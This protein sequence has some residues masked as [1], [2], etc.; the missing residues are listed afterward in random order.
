MSLY[1]I[2]LYNGEKNHLLKS[3]QYTKKVSDKIYVFCS[4]DDS[5]S[6]RD[7]EN[8]NIFISEVEWEQDFSKLRNHAIQVVCNDGATVRDWILSIDSDE[9][10]DPENYW[11]INS[12]LDTY[13]NN[14]S[15]NAFSVNIIN[16]SRYWLSNYDIDSSSQRK[17]RSKD[18]RIFRAS[19][20]MC[21]Q[22]RINE[23]LAVN[24]TLTCDLDLNI[25]H[26][27]CRYS[28]EEIDFLEYRRNTF[29][30]W[31]HLQETEKNA[32]IKEEDTFKKVPRKEL[33]SISNN[34]QKPVIGF[35]CLHYDPPIGGAE[36]SMHNYFSELKDF[37]D[38]TVFCFL[39]DNGNKFSEEQVSFKDGIKITKTPKDVAIAVND[40][41]E[42]EKPDV[43]LT[44][45]L[46]SEAV[47]DVAYKNGIPCI[48]FAHG[49]FEDVCQHYLLKS[50]PEND[51]QICKFSQACPNGVRHGIHATK[52]SRCSHI[53]C[54]SFYT[55][56]IFNRFFPNV[57]EKTSIVCPNF[58]YNFFQYK[59]KEE[60]T[61]KVLVANTMILKGR[62]VAINL[63][64]KNPEIHFIYVDSKASD[65]AGIPVPK[66]MEFLGR[67]PKEEM[68][69]LYGEVDAVLY[70]TFM[71]ETFGGIPSEA[72]LSGT[73]VVCPNKGNLENIVRNGKTGTIVYDSYDTEKWSVA[74]KQTMALNVS[75]EDRNKFYNSLD[76][77]G[78]V[79]KIRSKIEYCIKINEN[80]N[81]F[82]TKDKIENK[83]E[84]AK[85][86]SKKILFLAK[87]FYPPLGGGEYFLL[88]VLKFLKEECGY[89]CKAVC[90]ADANT[91]MPFHQTSETNWQG[92]SVQQAKVRSIVDLEGIIVREK[93]D[94]VV[95]QSY[96]APMIIKYAK[97]HG[98]KTILGTHFWRNICEAKTP[99]VYNCML[100][101]PME[102]VIN[103]TANHQA[104]Y[105][106]DE[107]YA[108]S[109]FMKLGIERYTKKNIQRIIH[110]I[111]DTKRVS[112]NKH[113]PKYITMINPDFYK[114]G[115]IFVQVAEKM[116]NY[117]FLCVGKAPHADTAPRNAEINR[118]IESLH[119]IKLI[120]KTDDISSIYEKTSILMVPS[121]VDETFCMVALEAMWNGIPIVAAP[122][123]N[124][125][126]LIDESGILID[127]LDIDV[128][129]ES[130]KS[131]YD[132]QEYYNF[133]S[134]K[135]K[136]RALEFSPEKELNKFK[137]MVEAC[138][139]G[140]KYAE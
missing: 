47:V 70:P 50:C 76:I 43:I 66:N 21:Y 55:E 35:F 80:N 89:N 73:P 15:I 93:P 37:Y 60:K 74:L 13:G 11:K 48:Y 105:M 92:L 40:F 90:Y 17:L 88:S 6:I 22:G 2:Y 72:I 125:P 123:G 127:V 95:T 65:L 14:L 84:E 140:S 100:N 67:V 42:K 132:N 111:L 56:K 9:C 81:I 137:E 133:M 98:V 44:Q 34:N 26:H 49:L 69:R 130:I 129:C 5:K 75:E 7:I 120:E 64:I 3:I 30:K 12:Y 108:N 139:G 115:G 94:L 106:A 52:Y 128:W 20:T 121:I 136:E 33:V 68:A 59:P 61:N 23:K 97:K 58:D 53:F 19:P 119:N 29:L 1:A 51:L 117:D 8:E 79:H 110:P 32:Y 112:I 109:E 36:R 102:S 45:L 85:K 116:P 77:K 122:N 134:Q 135:S 18:F 71:A 78:N 114:G 10:L 63:A 107:C 118:K 91:H 62:N 126:F 39:N 82:T 86:D 41:I 96:D 103:L 113:E 24:P 83:M 138:I 131:I 101:R 54:N 38:I 46:T 28:K 104:F 99:D 124:I 87:F 25:F 16:N 4:K 57:S 31:P 27:A